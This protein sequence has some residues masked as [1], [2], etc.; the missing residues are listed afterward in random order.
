MAKKGNLEKSIKME[1]LKLFNSRTSETVIIE[2]D[3]LANYDVRLWQVL[4]D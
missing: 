4:N 2:E 3:E 1:K